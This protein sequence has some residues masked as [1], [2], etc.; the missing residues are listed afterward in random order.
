V[1]QLGLRLD[2]DVARR[3]AHDL[4]P[5]RL[6]LPGRLVDHLPEPNLVADDDWW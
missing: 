1:L 3:P 4:D 6:L 2:G 5:D